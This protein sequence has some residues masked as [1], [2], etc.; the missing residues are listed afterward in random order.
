MKKIINLCLLLTCIGFCL[1]VNAQEHRHHEKL[2]K[3]EWLKKMT[4]FK[5]GFL[6]TELDLSEQQSEDFFEIYDAKENERS[7]V[8]R[9]LR[10][11]ERELSK[12]IENGTATDEEIEECIEEQYKFNTK[13]AEIDKKYEKQF[14]KHL[15]KKQL[16][17]LPHA[18]RKFMRILMERRHGSRPPK[19]HANNPL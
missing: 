6:V 1:S 15:T 13:M 3:E 16:F 8:E 7:A 17:K 11:M 19:P 18:E 5:H 4:E 9:K 2:N 10:K 12:K 14:R